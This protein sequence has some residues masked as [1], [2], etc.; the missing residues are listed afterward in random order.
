MREQLTQLRKV[1]QQNHI[2]AYLIP[3][4]D[5]HGSEYVNDYF[6]CRKYISGFTGSAGTLLVTAS[7]AFLWTD[8]RYFLQASEQLDGTGIQLMKM[9][10]NGVPTIMEYLAENLSPGEVL[11]FDGRVVSGSL[12]REMEKTLEPKG[13]CFATEDDL[14]DRIW[15]NRPAILPSTI[16]ALPESVTGE[17]A[18]SKLTRL[19]QV[20]GKENARYH[21]ITKM[22]EIAWIFNL[23]GNDVENTP[24]FFSYAL[25]EPDC[26]TLYVMDKSLGDRWKS[27]GVTVKGY[28]QLFDD[29]GRLDSSGQIWLDEKLVNCA[30]IKSLPQE[31]KII[32]QP[33]PAEMMKAIKNAVEISSTRN[34]HI[35]DGVA[36]VN[37]I[38]WLKK[39][40]GI[41]PMSEISASDYLESCRRDQEGCNDL[42]FETIS[43]Y[44]PNGAIIHYF[45][46]PE[47]DKPLAASG[48]LLVD[49]GGQYNDGTTDI[50]RTI[51]L[52]P[53]TDEMKE[54]YTAVLRCNIELAS[55]VFPEGTTGLELDVKTRKPLQV[56]GLDY[57]H[58]TGHGVGHLLSVHEGPNTISPSGGNCS[59]VPGMITSNEPGVYLEGKYGIRLENEL[60]CVDEATGDGASGLYA[61]ESLTLCPFEPAAVL[62]DKLTAGEI[63]YLNNYHRQ[64]YET[65]APLLTN[66]VREWLSEETKAL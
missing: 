45:A 57:N 56:L 61:F 43:G 1:M 13:I 46:T 26:A 18:M 55:S 52:G 59:I 50:T 40:I 65:L 49:S 58:G 3:T 9:S 10:Q 36:I 31:M 54:N 30:L 11:G 27:S 21:L 19:R 16:Y 32:N 29:L 14:I 6:K 4:T 48:F 8:G 60:L 23:R 51:A 38:Y 28:D 37:F 20:M 24:V 64:V 22:E 53:L 63:E 7:D 12:F 15:T 66:E 33:G 5:F 39:N 34:A 62:V 47:S 35:K 2:D 25:V 44:G 41:I 42:S 17:D